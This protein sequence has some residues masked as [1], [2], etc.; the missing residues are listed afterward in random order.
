MKIIKFTAENVKKLRVVEITPEHS[1]VEIVGHNGSG[2]SSVLDA[3]FYA[4]TGAA[5][6]PSKVVRQG[7]EKAFVRLDLGELVVTRH[8]TADGGTRLVVEAESG[9][10]FPSPQAMLDK[11]V[12][13]LS[14]DP[15][16]FTRMEPKQQ[17]ETL[18][19]MV[20]LD[21]DIDKLEANSRDHAA[22]RSLVSRD[23]KSLTAQ[24]EGKA[25]PAETVPGE[26]IDISSLLSAMTTAS[27]HNQDRQAELHRRA[28]EAETIESYRMRGA[29]L[30]KEAHTQYQEAEEHCKSIMAAAS[31]KF[32][33]QLMA[34]D[35]LLKTAQERHDE[36]FALDMLPELVDIT[37]LQQQVEHGQEVNRQVENKRQYLHLEARIADLKS[38]VD[39]HTSTINEN[40]NVK[41]AAIKAA[42]MPVDG[43]SFGEGEVLFKELPLVQASSAEQLAVSVAIA[44][45]ANPKLKVLRV[46]DGSLLDT[47]SMDQLAKM[48][49]LAGYQLWIERVDASGFN[50]PTVVMEDGNAHKPGVQAE[51]LVELGINYPSV[52]DIQ[53]VRCGICKKIMN[54]GDP[55]DNDCGGDCTSCMADAGDPDCIK[56]LEDSR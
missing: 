46:K 35:E 44:M 8:F 11:L 53:E 13:A 18:R 21:V 28:R 47:E 36:L 6:I 14:F 2:K 25:K 16:A 20:K 52:S 22:Q 32:N 38:K 24:L 34:R 56:T 54:T 7:E 40:Q 37:A 42:V 33:E 27:T 41:T 51:D 29:T 1:V 17:L 9:A 39:A 4:L 48:T 49:D 26:P 50:T 23:L 55:R 3:I 12:G 43:L 5:E 10:R 31:N 45:A 15:L 19:R 30:E